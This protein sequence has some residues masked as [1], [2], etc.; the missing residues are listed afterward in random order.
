MILDY[1]QGERHP[2]SKLT[3]ADVLE[4]RR[5]RLRGFQY[6]EIAKRFPVSVVTVR[7]VCLRRYWGHV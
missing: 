4:M 5:L 3:E 6:T 2:N 1:P 7:D